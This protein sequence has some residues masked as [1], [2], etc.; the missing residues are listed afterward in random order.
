[1]SRICHDCIGDDFLAASV[2]EQG[3]SNHCSYCGKTQEAVQL[4]VLADRVHEV[5]QEHFRLIPS[6]PEDAEGWLMQRLGHWPPFDGHSIADV[7]TDLVGEHE[8]FVRDLISLLADAYDP[9][10]WD[11]KD[12]LDIERAYDTDSE[13]QDRGPDDKPFR[14]RWDQFRREIQSRARF[15]SADAH[16][17]L[18]EIFGD[19]TT[20]QAFG[21]R[22]VIR[23]VRPSYE[24]FFF[25]RARVA[26][27][28]AE[29]EEILMSPTRELGPPPS[30][31]KGGH[32]TPPGGRM[33]APGVPVF[34]G[35]SDL[36]TCVAEVRAPVRS[37]VVAA[38]FG[39]LRT[40]RLLDLD[41]LANVYTTGSYFDPDLGERAGRA[42]FLRR[43][44]TLISQPVMPRDEATEYLPTQAIAEFLANRQQPRLDGIVFRSSQSN[45]NGYNIV[46]FNHARTVEPYAPPPG[47]DT[48][49]YIPSDSPGNGSDA[50]A[51][52]V[53][54]GPLDQAS[55]T[56]DDSAGRVPRL[57]LL[58]TRND[59]PTLALDRAS[60]VVLKIKGV[61]Y[62]KNRYPVRW[63]RFE[64][65]PQDSSS[66]MGSSTMESTELS[67]GTE[68][69]R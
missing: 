7:V 42:L 9:P 17:M 53:E 8:E 59:S 50:E 40:V 1:M 2:K 31:W 23:E 63:D 62:V 57:N 4:N 67:E 11:Y 55:E 51:L 24:E 27:S 69:S 39:V 48:W 12:S 10:T 46:L 28:K 19:L 43:L 65:S 37:Y 5:I 41:V 54:R 33:N 3:T 49:V 47:T 66:H 15:F 52:V 13:Y 16:M 30:L 56:S 36:P 32:I 61:E 21:D 60:L 45:T 38:K 34:Y 25:W 22:P 29:A 18:H 68:R 35:A 6:E 26:Q 20:L 58:K 14:S 44:A 64:V